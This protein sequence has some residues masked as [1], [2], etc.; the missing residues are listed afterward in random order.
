MESF[1]DG[2]LRLA[3]TDGIATVTLDRPATRNAMTRSMWQALPGL[4]DRLAGDDAVRVIVLTGAGGHFSAG[5]DVSEFPVVFADA[6][7]AR[8][9]NDLIQ[10]GL[11]ALTRV[12]HPTIAAIRGN[13]VGAGCG[14]SMACDLRF[15][16][17][18][19]RLAMPPAKLGANYP[20]DGTRQLVQLVGPA[21][22]KDMLFSGRL[23][24]GE[25]ALAIGL[26]DR[27]IPEDRFDAEVRAY[28][29]ALA[30]LSA[31]SLR[32]TKHIVRAICDGTERETPELKALFD[33]SFAGE[34]FR[35]GYRAFL[36]KRKP[37]FRP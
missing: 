3:I 21:R 4:M 10:A 12:P 23:V 24:G 33:D 6:G 31:S 37:R 30:D 7:A 25:E 14:L 36:E 19:A 18:G 22:A 1:A 32:T 13:A 15:A 28:A 29:D 17:E 26:I 11:D 34:D 35:E 27:L 8:T 20:F 16:A 5:A 9:H 2:G